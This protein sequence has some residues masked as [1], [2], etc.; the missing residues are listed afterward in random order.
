MCPSSQFLDTSIRST[1]V[2]NARLLHC[3]ESYQAGGAQKQESKS[4][5][6]GWCICIMYVCKAEGDNATPLCVVT[7][8][9]MRDEMHYPEDEWRPL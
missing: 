3:P 1:F 2:Q 9:L 5:S 8:A 6:R 7:A 4:R